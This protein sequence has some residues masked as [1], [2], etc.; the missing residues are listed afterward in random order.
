MKF[1][2][3]KEYYSLRK[4]KGVGLASAVVGLAFLAPSVMAEETATIN[5]SGSD[6]SLVNSVSD[7]SDSNILVSKPS[8][9]KS[10]VAEDAPKILEPNVGPTT[11]NQQVVRLM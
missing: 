4:F 2:D 5:V 11:N 10:T 1:K 7:S 8:V 6:V 9:D 3:K